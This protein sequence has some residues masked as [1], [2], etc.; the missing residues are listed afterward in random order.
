MANKA[1]IPRKNPPTLKLIKYR[2]CNSNIFPP[3]P[4]PGAGSFPLRGYEIIIIHCLC[5][6]G[7]KT[8]QLSPLRNLCIISEFDCRNSSMVP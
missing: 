1:V 7:A 5:H 2:D 3:I 6:P 8:F 4:Q